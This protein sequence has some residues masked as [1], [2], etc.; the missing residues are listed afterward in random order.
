MMDWV[1]IIFAMLLMGNLLCIEFKLISDL[2]E[3]DKEIK[4]LTITNDKLFALNTNL[5]TFL[6][7]KQKDLSKSWINGEERKN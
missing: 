1:L 7:I 4:R 6:K 2:K 5:I 3:A